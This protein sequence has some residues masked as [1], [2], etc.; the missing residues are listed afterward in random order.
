MMAANLIVYGWALVSSSVE[1]PRGTDGIGGELGA[2]YGHQG[3]DRIILY[4]LFEI[5]VTRG[6]IPSNHFSEHG[7]NPVTWPSKVAEE[8]MVFL[9]VGFDQSRFYIR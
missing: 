2:E 3:L 1:A 4:K 5:H 8:S 7:R 9:Y 6:R